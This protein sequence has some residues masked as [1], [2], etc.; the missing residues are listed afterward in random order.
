MSKFNHLFS[1]E[2]YLVLWQMHQKCI[3]K[4]PCAV[5]NASEMG[6][7]GIESLSK[8]TVVPDYITHTHKASFSSKTVSQDENTYFQ[9]ACLPILLFPC[10]NN[11]LYFSPTYY[12]IRPIYGKQS[13]KLICKNWTLS[14]LNNTNNFTLSNYFL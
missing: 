3:R 9:T 10:T 2:N 4:L 14:K 7:W 11:F 12:N 5:T 8:G 1:K 13:M 6:G